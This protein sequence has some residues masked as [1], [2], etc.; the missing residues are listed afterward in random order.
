MIFQDRRQAGEKLAQAIQSAPLPEPLVLALP[1]GGVPVGR[2]VARALSC[3][4]DIIPLMKIPIPW[5]PEASYGVVAMDGTMV[6][7]RPLVNRFD[8]SERELEIAASLV[9]REAK[10]RDEL[11]RRGRPFPDLTG[12]TIILVDDGLASG[13]SMLAAVSF[14]K[15]R[16]PRSVI[17]AAPVSSDQAY[18][19]LADEKGIDKIIVLVFDAEQLFELPSYYREFRP[20]TDED[21]IRELT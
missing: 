13:Y 19:M 9:L 5:S 8:L 18:R 2:A 21:V 4:F 15:K 10:R 16:S 17:V 14:A 11:Y 7:N 6:L 1:R 12:K 20:L 3:P